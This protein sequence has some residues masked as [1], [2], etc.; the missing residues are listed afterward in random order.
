[1][2]LVCRSNDRLCPD[3]RVV[4]RHA[5]DALVA[6]RGGLAASTMQSLVEAALTDQLGRGV[7]LD[8]AAVKALCAP[9][10]PI[11]QVVNIPPLDLAGCDR[12]LCARV[13][14]IS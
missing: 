5:H 1:M 14:C 11:E 3:R 13:C 10:K 12:L 8:H 6:S 2:R 4:F 9:D 7:R